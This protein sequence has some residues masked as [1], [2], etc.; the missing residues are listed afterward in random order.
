[1]KREVIC[2]VC[3]KGCHV[4]VLEEGMNPPTLGNECIRG[5]HYALQEVKQPMRMFTTT[6][7]LKNGEISRC[8]VMTRSPIPKE[9]LVEFAHWTQ[10]LWVEAPVELNQVLV[11][12]AMNLGVDLIA[13]RSLKKKP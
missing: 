10:G 7:A 6:I 2:T 13:T 11:E 8:P 4:Q 9:K 1:M 3:P 5:Q 12:N